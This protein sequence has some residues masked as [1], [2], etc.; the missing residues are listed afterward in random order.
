M[1]FVHSNHFSRSLRAMTVISFFCVCI[2]CDILFDV[3][4][5]NAKVHNKKQFQK[6]L[7][8]SFLSINYETTVIL[9]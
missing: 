9:Q 7:N 6:Y 1:N 2:V 5:L 3:I 4:N 8:L